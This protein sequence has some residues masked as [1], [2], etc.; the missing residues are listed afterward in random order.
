MSPSF[1]IMLSKTDWLQVAEG[2][3]KSADE[4]REIA[5]GRI[6]TGQAAFEKGLVD[7][8]GGLEDA[9][10][11]AKQEAGLPLEVPSTAKRRN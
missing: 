1:S 8:L 7:R 6:W 4:V 2:R 5:Q 3:K 10:L 11:L 9:I